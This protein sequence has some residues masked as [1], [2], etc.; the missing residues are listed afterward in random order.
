MTT[1]PAWF[2]KEYT[3]VDFSDGHPSSYQPRPTSVS[4]REPVFPFCERRT[5]K[6][7]VCV[8]SKSIVGRTLYDLS[9]TYFSPDVMK[10]GEE[11]LRDA[12]WTR[13]A[14]NWMKSGTYLILIPRHAQSLNHTIFRENTCLGIYTIFYPNVGIKDDWC[15]SRIHRPWSGRIFKKEVEG[16]SQ[17]CSAVWRGQRALPFTFLA[18]F[19]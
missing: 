5:A 9:S 15:T 4:K 14:S 18:F 11:T 8:S 16:V 13:N 1:T 12:Y 7:T 2:P 17:C 19:K 10:K 3:T 6:V